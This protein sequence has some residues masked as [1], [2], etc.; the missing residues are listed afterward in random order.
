MA[1]HSVGD[2]EQV[3]TLREP[4][5]GIRNQGDAAVLIILAAKSNVAE[6]RIFDRLFPK[7]G[8]PSDE[9]A[10]QGLDRECRVCRSAIVLAASGFP[11]IDPAAIVLNPTHSDVPSQSVCG[12]QNKCFPELASNRRFSDF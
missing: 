10:Q 2:D 1:S 3:P 7:H 11:Q 5:W 9:P 6:G 12:S 8:N 4:F